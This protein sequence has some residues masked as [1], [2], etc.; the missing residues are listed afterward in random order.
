MIGGGSEVVRLGGDKA[1]SSFGLYQH[2]HAEE[3]AAPFTLASRH[4]LDLAIALLQNLLHVVE[5]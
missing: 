3:E 1:E 4:H 2:L 5:P